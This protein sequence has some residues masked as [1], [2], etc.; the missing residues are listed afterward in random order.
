MLGGLAL[1]AVLMSVA[2]IGVAAQQQPPQ[3]SPAQEGF[4]PVDRLPA[5][6]QLPATPLVIGAYAVAW[7]AVFGY[8]ISIWARLGK[9]EREIQVVSRRIEPGG[10]R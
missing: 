5:Q 9:V 8:L 3:Q 6:E 7:V 4:V 2:D 10:R 1:V